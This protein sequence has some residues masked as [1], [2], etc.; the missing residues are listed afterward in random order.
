M[1]DHEHG[2]GEVGWGSSSNVPTGSSEGNVNLGSPR[3]MCG[4]QPPAMG[5]SQMGPGEGSHL[6]SPP[7]MGRLAQ[8][9][10]CQGPGMGNGNGNMGISQFQTW[11]QNRMPLCEAC[12][13]IEDVC[14]ICG[15]CVRP[16]CGNVMQRDE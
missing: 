7:N 4:N 10:I 16:T 15:V 14:G 12:R 8:V 3:G 11:W 9:S 1:R 6:W 5:A 13:E 2:A